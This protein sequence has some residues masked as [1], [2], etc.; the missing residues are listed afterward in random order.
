M[1]YSTPRCFYTNIA[2]TESIVQVTPKVSLCPYLT[3]ADLCVGEAVACGLRR[4]CTHTYLLCIPPPTVWQ[5]AKKVGGI[6]CIREGDMED[7]C[8]PRRYLWV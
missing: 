1:D 7:T 8:G 5:L 4:C 3:P 6:S 2:C